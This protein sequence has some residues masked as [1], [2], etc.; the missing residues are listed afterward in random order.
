MKQFLI[1]L[2]GILAICNFQKCYAYEHSTPLRWQTNYEAAVAES[3]STSKPLLLFFTGSD[4][5]GWCNKLEE[6]V[7]DTQEF[8]ESAGNK[9]V[10]LKVDFPLYSPLNEKLTAQNK[11]LQKKY[12]VRSFPTIILLDS[13]NQQQIGV[14][15]YRPGGAKQYAMHLLKMVNDFS[16]YNDKMQ[17]L[18]KQK[19]TGADLK[20]LYEKAKELELKNDSNRLVQIGL[21]SDQK[22]YFLIEKYHLL[23]K[24]GNIRH[25]EAAAV[26]QQ[27]VQA[28]PDNHLMLQYQMAV[29][30]FESYSEEAE[31][32]KYSP[33]LTVAPLLK[34]IEKFGQ[35]DK[36]NLW[37]LQMIISQVFLDNNKLPQALE[38]ARLS[39]LSAPAAVQPEIA[40]AIKNI[41]H[42]VTH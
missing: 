15:G 8:M 28:D 22:P 33:E 14:T 3:K 21:E 41:P 11:D 16:S 6:E 10:F 35:Q 1:F 27:L 4:W 12:D 24:Q 26:R 38:Y 23:A 9:F 18:D 5:C 39:Y 32:D 20:Q 40:T 2:C 25:Q 36:E 37:R 42:A 31:K 29:I 13:R 17:H 34:Y 7:L 19:I 30:E